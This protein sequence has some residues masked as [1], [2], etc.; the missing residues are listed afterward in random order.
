MSRKI[1]LVDDAAT[2]RM[3]IRRCFEVIGL[4]DA[5]FLEASDGKEGLK[6]AKENDVDLIVT[7]LNMP[8]MDGT[9]FVR[10]A[11]GSPKLHEVPII[12]ITSLKNE[13]KEK[14]LIDMGVLA[15]LSKPIA[16]PSISDVLEQLEGWIDPNADDLL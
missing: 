13:A 10:R 16:P 8:N 1:L 11:K 5:T 7:D 15:V 6:V 4:W 12:V 14:E 9:S 3:F 2:A